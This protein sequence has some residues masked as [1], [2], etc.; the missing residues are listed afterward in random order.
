MSESSSAS[1]SSKPVKPLQE[2]PARYSWGYIKTLV[3]K[4]RRELIKA[5]II[6]ILG[7]LAA[8]PVPLLLPLLVDEVL[9]EEA[10]PVIP[11]INSLTPE[12]LHG[13]IFYV[14]VMVVGALILRSLSLVMNVWQGRQFAIIA[15]DI[16]YRIRSGLLRRLQFISM[17][18][19]EALGSGS[20]ASRFV[21]DL[22]TIDQFLGITIS[23][24]LVALLTIVGTA[25]ILLWVHWK[26]GLLV[27]LCNPFVIY[28]TT[29]LGK[30]VKEL[31][32]REN[33]A[34]EVFQEA[35][36]ETLDAIHQIRAANREE[37]YLTR[38][39]GHARNVREHAVQYEWKSDAAN[40]FSFMLFLFG[41]DIFRATAMLTVLFSDLSI[42]YM[43][44]IFGYLWFMMVPVQEILGM[45]YN[46]FA[47]KAALQ[48]VNEL[49]A[50]NLEP[51]YPAREDPFLNRRTV[52]VDVENVHFAYQS[53]QEVLRGV[54]VN[55][56]PGEKVA[57][58]GASGG[59]KSTLVQVLLGMY[60]PSQGKVKY[61]GVPIEDIG[62]A[63]V[64]QNVV[65]VL[66]HPSLFNA[67]VRENLSLG[68]E[69][70][71]AE[72][73]D[74]LTVAQLDDVISR[75]PQGL[76]TELG[77]QGVRM[78]GG[79]KQR[80]AVARMILANPKVVI[81]D[82]ATSALDAETEFRLHEALA[83]FL[84]H[85][86]TIIIAHRLSAVKQADRVYVFDG[87]QIAEEGSHSELLAQEGLYAQLYGV[88]QQ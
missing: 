5:N 53:G 34:F 37:H 61:G 71:D 82:E 87:G 1:R 72:L 23:R 28:L 20:V 18:E 16:V 56:V 42:G 70:S 54:S 46:Y 58:V 19:Y 80:L 50:L 81:L 4:H 63:R 15:K 49:L 11:F 21:T 8:V 3:L 9:L 76:D 78:S 12:N 88:R 32:R 48:R 17:A 2:L 45:Q 43:F 27:I 68:H 35:L 25:L 62:H 24:F 86:T 14:A 22:N 26:L 59:G 79:Q 60:S 13:P 41:V 6:A 39:V 69:H 77:R 55:I 33:R 51:V 75:M 44:A 36:T 29:R 85:R 64:R 65:T 84:Q 47:A 57:L 31:K 30:K 52:S 83:D 73:W 10:G 40:R 66:Q 38:L 74:A 67:S 7:T